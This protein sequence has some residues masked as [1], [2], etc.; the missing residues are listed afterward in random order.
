MFAY[1]K[2]TVSMCFTAWMKLGN[3]VS[4]KKERWK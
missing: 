1:E 4:E 2:S 3:V